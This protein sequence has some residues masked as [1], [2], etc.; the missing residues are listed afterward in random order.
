MKGN[1]CWRARNKLKIEVKLEN[2][3][4]LESSEI[5]PIEVGVGPKV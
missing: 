5:G 3:V 1:W 2:K 4:K